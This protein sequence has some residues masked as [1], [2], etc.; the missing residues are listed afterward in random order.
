MDIVNLLKES[1]SHD[2]THLELHR[3]WKHIHYPNILLLKSEHGYLLHDVDTRAMI[4]YDYP[5]FNQFNNIRDTYT[6][7]VLRIRY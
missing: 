1:P 4:Y 6:S 7:G 5:D 3:V 2:I